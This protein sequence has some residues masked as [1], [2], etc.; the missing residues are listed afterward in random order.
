[1]AVACRVRIQVI[2]MMILRREEVLQRSRLHAKKLPHTPFELRQC[3][4]DGRSIAR[5]NPVDARSVLG[6]S[7]APLAVER[8]WVDSAEVSL[9]QQR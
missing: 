9:K 7:V 1:M 8:G 2:L 3:R 6:A 5:T 4:S